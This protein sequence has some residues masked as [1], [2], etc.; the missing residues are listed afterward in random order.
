MHECAFFATQTIFELGAPSAVMRS[1]R[2]QDTAAIFKKRAMAAHVPLSERSAS[3]S[4]AAS[5]A[6]AS[7][8]TAGS[9]E[10]EDDDDEDGHGG[11]DDDE[12]DDDHDGDD[13]EEN[14]D[15]NEEEDEEE[16]DDDDDE[17][18][19]E[20]R[21]TDDSTAADALLNRPIGGSS[22][23]S[24]SSSS[25]SL[26]TA[27][28]KRSKISSFRDDRFYINPLPARNAFQDAQYSISGSGSGS[29][30]GDRLDDFVLDLGGEN[31]GKRA[32]PGVGTD[33]KRRAV[34][35]VF[36]Q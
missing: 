3:A 34:W 13:A 36:F 21:F 20:I 24:S 4:A 35:R 31:E 12:D 5:S 25:F 27:G 14:D 17:D 2:G 6:S 28:G 18:E 23:S 8:S 32:G 30:T 1:K 9:D 29:G 33:G 26:A 15:D 10:E 16:N 19:L 22:S 11:D 7:D